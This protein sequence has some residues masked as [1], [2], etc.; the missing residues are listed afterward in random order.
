MSSIEPEV[1]LP[2][3]RRDDRSERVRALRFAAVLGAAFALLG[4]V[5]RFRRHPETSA[6]L[7]GA[8]CG[9]VLLALATPRAALAVERGWL[10]FA[11]VL[12]RINGTLILGVAYFVVLSPLALLFRAV[13][14]NPL[15]PGNGASYF[16]PRHELRGRERFEEPY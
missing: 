3:R 16:R 1:T 12:G 10:T 2:G 14:R 9:L 8:A 4:L 13:R 6:V 5:A 11:S 7:V 15:R